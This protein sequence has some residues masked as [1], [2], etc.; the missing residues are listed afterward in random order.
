VAVFL[1]LSISSGRL[2]NYITHCSTFRGST[3]GRG[4]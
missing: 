1:K 4:V 3:A 2:A